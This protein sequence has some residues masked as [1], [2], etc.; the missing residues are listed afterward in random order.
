VSEKNPFFLGEPIFM[1]RTLLKDNYLTTTAWTTE[2]TAFVAA[3]GLALYK[4]DLGNLDVAR[5]ITTPD[6]LFPLE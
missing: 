1:G 5:T 2:P 6:T 4:W 3:D